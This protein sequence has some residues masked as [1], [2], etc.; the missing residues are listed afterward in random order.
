MIPNRDEIKAELFDSA[1]EGNELRD[2]GV[3]ET[4]MYTEFEFFSCL[5]CV[6]PFRDVCS[7]LFSPRFATVEAFGALRVCAL[8]C[9]FDCHAGSEGNSSFPER[10]GERGF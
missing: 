6:S 4:G 3:L 9:S 5:P 8:S 10:C 1:P 2:T 7:R